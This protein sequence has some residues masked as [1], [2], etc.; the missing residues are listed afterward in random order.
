[1]VQSLSS[2]YLAFYT[3]ILLGLFVVY[4]F[5][6]ERR[7]SLAFLGKLALVMA[8]ALV[9]MLP[10]ILPYAQVQGGQ[11][12]SRDLFQVER[13]SN[14]LASFLAVYQYVGNPIYHKL[15]APFADPG[16][17]PW[18]RSSFPGVVVLLLGL[19]GIVGTLEGWKVGR[20]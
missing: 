10:I 19:L 12:F 5:L 2:H 13:Y 18:E 8:V 20:L 7:F 3:V 11:Q 9:L 15:L 14:T 6:V 17:W 1:V 4:Y 16:P